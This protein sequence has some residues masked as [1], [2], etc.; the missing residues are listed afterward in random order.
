MK[1]ILIGIAISLTILPSCSNDTNKSTAENKPT[2]DSSHP[3]TASNNNTTPGS[4]IKG[5][6]SQ[7]FN[8]KNAL[9][10]DDGKEAAVAGKAIVQTMDKLDTA[11]LSSDQRKAYRDL[12]EDTRENAEHIG[13]NADKIDHQR[14]HFEMLS[15]D[16][17]DLVKKFGTDQTVYQ[18][19]CPMY[20]NGKGATWISETKDIKN[21]YLGKR[22]P[23][24][25]SVKEEIK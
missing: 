1:T 11:S 21:P 18:D 16:M 25:G 7:Y 5:I 3:A 22:M 19:F 12:Q 17:Y 13:D 15:K 2:A 23:T 10:N 4:S 8:L 14:E 9:T 24:C 6:V 20:N